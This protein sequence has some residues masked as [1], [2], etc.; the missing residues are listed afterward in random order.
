M[1]TQDP[2]QWIC[3]AVV[4]IILSFLPRI[5][6]IRCYCTDAH[7]N[8]YGVCESNVCL[9]GL[10][11]ANNA[12]IRTCGDEPIGC[13]REL[14]RWADLCACDQPFCNTFSYLR[15]NTRRE[16]GNNG[17]FGAA[18]PLS[19]ADDMHEEAPL[20][21]Q[22]VDTPLGEFS[23]GYDRPPAQTNTNTLVFVLVPL[24]VGCVIVFIVW[25]NYYRNLC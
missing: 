25:I 10:L 5:E 15:S 24:S 17:D 16:R 12:V 7:C 1:P 3:F 13:Q 20:I 8:P 14:G 19:H 4:V 2:R 18:P 22:R 21:F 23:S 9:V 11:K 6:S